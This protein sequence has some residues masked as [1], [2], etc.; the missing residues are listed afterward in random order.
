MFDFI[1]AK[2]FWLHVNFRCRYVKTI[3]LGSVIAEL[4][5]YFVYVLY[6]LTDGAKS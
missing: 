6:L 3:N 1:A 2:L 4:T 5:Y